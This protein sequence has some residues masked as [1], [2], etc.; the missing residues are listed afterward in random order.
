[1]EAREVS[2]HKVCHFAIYADVADKTSF[3][4][5]WE[6]GQEEEDSQVGEEEKPKQG[7]M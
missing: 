7:T 6:E 2:P 3:Q 4:R 5:N 1:M